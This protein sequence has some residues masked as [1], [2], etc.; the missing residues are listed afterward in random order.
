M[1]TNRFNLPAPIFNAV[2]KEYKPNPERFSVTDLIGPPLIRHLKLK[3][4]EELSEDASERPWM[5][6]GS[7]VDKVISENA[8]GAVV[9]HKF[10]ILIDGV[11]IVGKLDIWYPIAEKI[12]DWKVTSVWSFLL[13]DKKDWERQLNCYAWGKRR[14]FIEQK[15]DNKISSLF[16]NAILRDWQKSKMLQDR[17]YPRIPFVSKNIPLWTFEEQEQYI[18]QQ[19]EYHRMAEPKECS[20]EEKWERPTKFA[21][22]K[23]GRKSALRVLDSESEAYAWIEE[24]ETAPHQKKWVSGN[25]SVIERPG[26][27]VRCLNYCPVRGV[28]PYQTGEKNE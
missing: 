18:K 11:V 15:L 6:L 20:S 8:E 3:H 7:A 5:L 28:C 1:I 2:N 19:L 17:D 25:I 26:E 12:E 16:I 22:M 14:E 4:W 23:K 10:E 21:V 9:Q 24:Q 27:C 13:G